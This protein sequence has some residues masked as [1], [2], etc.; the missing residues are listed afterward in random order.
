MIAYLWDDINHVSDAYHN[1][2]SVLIIAADLDTAR[3]AWVSRTDSA[4]RL[5]EKDEIR[6]AID[7]EPT[8]TWKLAARP[9][10]DPEIFTFPDAGACC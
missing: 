1:N 3:A 5:L 9:K 6:Q 4:E 10:V 2:G 7:G 8:R